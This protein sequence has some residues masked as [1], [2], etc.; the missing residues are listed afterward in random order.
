MASKDHGVV[1]QITTA[2]GLHCKD[3][4]RVATSDVI[5]NAT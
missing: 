3:R 5:G 4:K 2:T 1:V